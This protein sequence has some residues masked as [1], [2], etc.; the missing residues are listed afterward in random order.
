MSAYSLPKL[1]GVRGSVARSLE[2]KWGS[3][4]D[5]GVYLLTPLRNR[6]DGA[7]ENKMAKKA[8]LEQLTLGTRQNQKTP[9]FF[10]ACHAPRN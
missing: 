5:T 9:S 4:T 8:T 10:L 1:D 2:S 6:G 3:L 7:Q